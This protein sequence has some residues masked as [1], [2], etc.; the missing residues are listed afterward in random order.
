MKLMHILAAGAAVLAS[1]ACN[2]EKGADSAAASSAPIKPIA[3]PNNGDWSEMVAETPEGGF[4]MGNPNAPVKLVEYGSMTCPHCATFDE[5][6]A[7][8]LVEK[9]VKSGQ[10][11]FEYRPHALFPTDPGIFALLHCRGAEPYFQLVEQLYADQ[12]AWLGRIQQYAQTNSAALEAMG[13]PERA[14]AFIRGGELDQFFRQRGM[15]QGQIDSCVADANNLQRIADLTRRAGEEHGIN[16][17]PTFMINDV[18]LE[19]VGSWEAL[20]PQI[21]AQL[22]G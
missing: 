1:A 13:A 19:N 6:G 8:P 2:A 9:Y 20:E 4:L 7:K 12:A 21:R 16:S 10:V 22:G 18:K 11:S 17:T 15:P 5:E 3:A 14:A